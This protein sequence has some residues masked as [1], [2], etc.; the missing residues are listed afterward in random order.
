MEISIL[1]E[2]QVGNNQDSQT[3]PRNRPSE[4]ELEIGVDTTELVD[5]TTDRLLEQCKEAI[6]NDDRKKFLTK[7]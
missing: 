7:S 6:G 1:I 3:V 4:Q 5:V 2:T